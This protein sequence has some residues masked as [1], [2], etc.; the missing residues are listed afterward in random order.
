MEEIGETL[1]RDMG[2]ERRNSF[3][4]A[5]GYFLDKTSGDGTRLAKAIGLTPSAVTEYKAGRRYGEEERR[6]KIAEFFG[7]TYEGFIAVGAAVL[8]QDPNPEAAGRAD[9]AGT[10]VIVAPAERLPPLTPADSR[11][12]AG[13]SVE[14]WMISDLGVSASTLAVHR[15]LTKIAF[16]GPALLL[17]DRAK[18]GEACVAARHGALHVVKMPG[19]ADPIV[20]RM[21]LTGE[22]WEMIDTH[23]N[24]MGY[25]TKTT[26]LGRVVVAILRP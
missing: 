24:V 3:H 6:R 8:A 20:V 13:F 17:V 5:L 19:S 4:A 26:I 23:G 7:L 2:N 12:A 22:G 9:S 15:G 11:Y 25:S 10:A 1:E 14:D 16:D 18:T 21:F